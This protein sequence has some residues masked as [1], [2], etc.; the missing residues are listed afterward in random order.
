MMMTQRNVSGS[1]SDDGTPLGYR[2]ALY[3]LSHHKSHVDYGW[4]ES[5]FH[6][7]EMAAINHA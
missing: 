4:T 3:Y 2:P 7:S 1:Q 6:H 5:E